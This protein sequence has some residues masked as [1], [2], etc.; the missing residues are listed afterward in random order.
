MRSTKSFTVDRDGQEVIYAC[1]QLGAWEGSKALI[2]AQKIAVSGI[3]GLD[4]LIQAMTEADL[5][6]FQK[7]FAKN[8]FVTYMNDKE[9]RVKKNLAEVFDVF[10]SGNLFEMTQWLVFCLGHDFGPFF[11]QI[12]TNGEKIKSQWQ[13]GA[14]QSVDTASEPPT[15]PEP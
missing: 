15:E 3:N 7:L 14:G 13:A 5:E 4:A 9:Q 8:T 11:A 10:F 2:R 12:Q 1:T 6:Y